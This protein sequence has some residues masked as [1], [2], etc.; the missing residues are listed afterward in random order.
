MEIHGN[1]N[2]G[3][4]IRPFGYQS[5]HAIAAWTRQTSPGAFADRILHTQP[6]YKRA[7]LIEEMK[8]KLHVV[9]LSRDGTLRAVT[10]V[11]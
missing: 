10:E 7:E 1:K 4:D 2:K 6:A 9:Q 11:V 5:R 8:R 3:T